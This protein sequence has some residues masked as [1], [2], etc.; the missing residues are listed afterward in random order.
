M[1]STTRPRRICTPAFKLSAAGGTILL[2]DS[3]GQALD[4]VEYAVQQED[5]SLGRDAAGEWAIFTSPTPGF[6][7]DEAG[8]AAFAQTRVA[9]DTGLILTEVMPSNNTTLA[10]ADGDYSDYIEIYNQG[11][12]AVDLAGFLAF[13]QPGQPRQMAF[14][15]DDDIAGRAY[16][17]VCVGQR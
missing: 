5:V 4:A 12:E 16:R 8:A 9:Q 3:A 2:T 10:D 15:G 17:G 13:R 7:N 1:W 14:P 6:S 11:S